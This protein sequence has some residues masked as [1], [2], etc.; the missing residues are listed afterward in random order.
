[1]VSFTDPATAHVSGAISA[2]TTDASGSG[3]H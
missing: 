1:M 2:G 3:M